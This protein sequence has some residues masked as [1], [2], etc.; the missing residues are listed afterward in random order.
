[1]RLH[2]YTLFTFECQCLCYILQNGRTPLNCA[3]IEGHLEVVKLLVERG[4]ADVNSKAD[5]SGTLQKQYPLIPDRSDKLLSS[6]QLKC[7]ADHVF[8][9][10]ELG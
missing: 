3:C 8:F 5:V 2:T 7:H 10:S 9:T 6:D 1:M 4:G